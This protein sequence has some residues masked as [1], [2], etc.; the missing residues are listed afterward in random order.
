MKSAFE[1]SGFSNDCVE[2]M[3]HTTCTIFTVSHCAQGNPG[4][5]IRMCPSLRVCVVTVNTHVCERQAGCR[6]KLH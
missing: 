5:N 2:Q 4:W 6:L 3:P 1:G